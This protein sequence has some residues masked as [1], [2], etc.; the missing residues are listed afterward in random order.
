MSRPACSRR[1]RHG[2]APE[3]DPVD[4]LLLGVHDLDLESLVGGAL[5]R[6][7][8][9]PEDRGHKPAPRADAVPFPERGLGAR[10][11]PVHATPPPPPHRPTGPHPAGVP[12]HAELALD[13]APHPP[14]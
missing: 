8:D 14:D 3:A 13:P 7:G 4:P 11:D 10:P 2:T 6:P 12:L 1:G 9:P 5:A